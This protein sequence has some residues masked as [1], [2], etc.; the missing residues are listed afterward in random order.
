MDNI[1]FNDLVEKV[2]FSLD[3]THKGRWVSPN[4]KHKDPDIYRIRVKYGITRAEM[5]E[6]IGVSESTVYAWE[7]GIREPERSVFLLLRIADSRPEAF[8]EALWD[9]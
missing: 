1:R 9:Y 5:A 4:I 7:Q 3:E 6:M 8:L 2:R